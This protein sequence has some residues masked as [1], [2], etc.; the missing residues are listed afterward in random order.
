MSDSNG[1]CGAMGTQSRCCST[2]LP[3]TP[4]AD[5]EPHRTETMRESGR[6]R[7]KNLERISNIDLTSLGNKGVAGGRM[8]KS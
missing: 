4:R 5:A 7:R 2:R 1:D 6:L 8:E 3:I